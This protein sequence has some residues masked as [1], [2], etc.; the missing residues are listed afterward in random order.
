MLH[1]KIKKAPVIQ[2]LNYIISA[3]RKYINRTQ[4]A[5]EV[6]YIPR[7]FLECIC[8][9]LRVK[10]HAKQDTPLPRSPKDK[11]RTHRINADTC[12]NLSGII[13]GLTLTMS[14]ISSGPT[15]F[16]AA[17]GTREAWAGSSVSAQPRV[18]LETVQCVL[19][20]CLRTP[21]PAP[22]EKANVQ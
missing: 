1:T 4:E 17:V 8:H 7:Y 16:R 10:I 2:A 15:G 13:K 3:F 20:K 5:W 19:L 12:W 22:S 9:L 6:A 21:R 14:S 18:K 11:P